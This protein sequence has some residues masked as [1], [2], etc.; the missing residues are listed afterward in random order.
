MDG[1]EAVIVVVGILAANTPFYVMVA[2]H[3]GKL[4]KIQAQLDLVIELMK[5]GKRGRS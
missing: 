3:E 2:K 1:V 4:V 5:A